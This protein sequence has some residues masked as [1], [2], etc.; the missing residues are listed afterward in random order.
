MS[1]NDNLTDQESRFAA[2]VVKTLDQPLD[3]NTL[4]RLQAAREAA[5]QAAATSSGTSLR[6]WLAGG[7][8]GGAMAAGVALVFLLQAP[9]IDPLPA[10]SDSE[11]AAAAELELLESLD[12]LAWLD[13]EML[14]AEETDDG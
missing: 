2:Q 7:S 5:V 13:E 10:L 12:M 9:S 8:V 3:E 1:D 11:L 14:S 4:A 6:P